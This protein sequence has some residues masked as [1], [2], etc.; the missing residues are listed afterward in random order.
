MARKER[1]GSRFFSI[2]NFALKDFLIKLHRNST[3]FSY[4]IRIIVLSM[5][6]EASRGMLTTGNLLAHR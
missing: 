1:Q 6:L 2:F 5:E 3:L 4:C